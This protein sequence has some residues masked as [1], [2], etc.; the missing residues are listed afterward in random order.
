MHTHTHTENRG[1]TYPGILLTEER[2]PIFTK[3][4][5]HGESERGKEKN[6]GENPSEMRREG[7]QRRIFSPPSHLKLPALL[8]FCANVN[9]REI[10]RKNRNRGGRHVLRSLPSGSGERRCRALMPCYA[11]VSMCREQGPCVSPWRVRGIFSKQSKKITSMLNLKTCRHFRKYLCAILGLGYKIPFAFCC[12][13]CP[14]G[15]GET[16]LF[17]FFKG[18]IL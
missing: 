6:V 3:G 11:T 9:T 5:N 1:Y 15:E 16:L 12:G 2:W 14:V 13:N 4:N 18:S 8:L 7:G 17:N 10:Q